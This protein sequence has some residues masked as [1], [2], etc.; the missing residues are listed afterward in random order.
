MRAVS[1]F[2]KEQRRI[3]NAERLNQVEMEKNRDGA[4]EVPVLGQ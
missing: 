4:G 1:V 3:P 2:L